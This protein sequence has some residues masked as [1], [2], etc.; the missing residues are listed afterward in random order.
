MCDALAVMRAIPTALGFVLF[1]SA[2]AA[3]RMPRETI[4]T[5]GFFEGAFDDNVP[6]KSDQTSEARAF[7][8][9]GEEIPNVRQWLG[10]TLVLLPLSDEGRE[11]EAEILAGDSAWRLH[12]RPGARCRDRLRRISRTSPVFSVR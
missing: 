11:I 1:F 9:N 10:T 2:C 7:L 3:H 5:I 6:M 4:V 8:F 12:L